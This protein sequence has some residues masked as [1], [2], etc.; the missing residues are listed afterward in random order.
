MEV[1]FDTETRSLKSIVKVGTHNHLTT[2]ASDLICLAYRI[3]IANPT[4]LWTPEDPVPDVFKYPRSHLF[5]A[6]N[7]TFDKLAIDFLGP[8]YGFG[9]IP[10]ENCVDVM[11][12]ASR[13]GLPS[14]LSKAGEAM[15]L[16]I[17]KSTN[18]T[19]LINKISMPPWKY[20]QKDLV[21][22]FEYCKNDVNTMCELLSS[23]PSEEL[24]EEE[25]QNWINTCKINL[26]GIPIDI[27]LVRRIYLIVNRYI[28]DLTKDVSLLTNGKVQTINQR[29]AIMAWAESKGVKLPDF[30]KDAVDYFLTKFD[31]PPDVRAVL[32]IRK[33][34]GK[35]SIKKYHTLLVNSHAVLPN[36]TSSHRI[37]INL[38]YYGSHTG[39][40]A[41]WNFQ[42]QNL[43]KGSLKTEEQIEAEIQ[44]FK[45]LSVLKR[46]PVE[47]AK[48][49][50]RPMIKASFNKRLAVHD[51]SSIEHVLLVWLARESEALENLR[52]GGDNYVEFAANFYQILPTEVTSAQRGFGKT[53]VLGCGYMMGAPRL[54]DTCEQFGIATNYDECQEAVHLFRHSFPRIENLWYQLKNCAV[55]ALAN[56][57]ELYT[58][59]DCTFTYVADRHSNPW[60]ML[61]LPSG[62]N[63]FY[64]EPELEG[65]DYGPVFTYMGVHSQTK[66][67]IRL[68]AGPN[69]IIENIVQ[70]LGRDVLMDGRGR[71]LKKYPVIASIHDENITEVPELEYQRH[72]EYIKQL[73]ETPPKWCR[74]MPLKVSGY[75][76]KRY[77]KD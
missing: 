55:S 72:W 67:Y 12:L 21:E 75:C 30:T 54:L 59:N 38:K 6:F 32:T 2:S 49:L 74:N 8:K 26:T 1:Y 70:A 58:I 47:S 10:I 20:T 56:P 17:Q 35:T 4:Q 7:I 18:G 57:G 13:Y 11:A 71:V 31:L 28:K 69:K 16:R 29:A 15:N 51:Y 39:R 76:E 40:E 22:F 60:L 65:D 45:D 36:P 62:R 64:R 19:R 44:S 34:V 46:N 25:Q 52:Q 37:Y 43:P 41:G 5:Y 73:M 66:K 61:T 3:G 77:R 27:P 33:E 42:I 24:S 68:E 48:N 14:S 23:L 9:S 53:A 63:L 50:I